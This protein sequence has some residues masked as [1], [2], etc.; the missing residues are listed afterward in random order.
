MPEL[1]ALEFVNA[2]QIA[3]K[4]SAGNAAHSVTL[5]ERARLAADA[6]R[7]ELLREGVSFCTETVFSHP[8][9]I[10]LIRRAQFGGYEVLLIFIG[11]ES[12]MLSAARVGFR[13]QN[14]LGHDVPYQK[15]VT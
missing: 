9:K 11:V 13:V 8:S 7:E 6:R 14:K 1:S 12:A 3:Q 15:I 10:K 2:D 4:F 5:A